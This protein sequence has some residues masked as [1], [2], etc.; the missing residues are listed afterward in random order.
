MTVLVALILLLMTA[1]LMFGSV[2]IPAAAV[3]DLLL[4]HEVE[5]SS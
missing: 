1:S 2:Q 4:G 3:A 5:K